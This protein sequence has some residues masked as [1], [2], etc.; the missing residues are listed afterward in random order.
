MVLWFGCMDKLYGHT[1][2]MEWSEPMMTIS[3]DTVQRTVGSKTQESSEQKQEEKI[4]EAVDATIKKVPK[5]K[6]QIVPK[7]LSPT[8]VDVKTT[9]TVAP[10]KVK[11]KVKVNTATKI[12]L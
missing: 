5:A 6:N 2:T 12:K 3:Q 7:T 1:S 9:T 8:K 10:V 4:A 11:V